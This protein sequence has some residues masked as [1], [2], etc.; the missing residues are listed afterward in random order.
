MPIF[1]SIRHKTLPGEVGEAKLRSHA[2]PLNS[3]KMAK[4]GGKTVQ[5][6]TG[7]AMYHATS[8]QARRHDRIQRSFIF[9]GLRAS[10]TCSENRFDNDS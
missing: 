2:A 10:Y 8:A 5:F 7:A 6:S 9:P 4:A 3:V 1:E